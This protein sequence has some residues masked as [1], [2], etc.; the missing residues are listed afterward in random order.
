MKKLRVYADTSV[1]GGCFDEEF[2]EASK[3]F[4]E[5]VRAGRFEL[6]ISATTLR[7]LGDAPDRVQA[8][9]DEL[10]QELYKVVELTS[11]IESLRDKY[12][13]RGVVGTGSR[14][15]AEHI[16]AASA[17]GVDLIISWNFRHIVHFEKIRGYHAVNLVEGY[18]EIPIH[19]PREV[20]KRE[21]EGV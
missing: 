1:F 15:D 13:D 12:V 16:A 17:E 11:E 20:V 5:E 14:A 3:R 21:D 7:E 2:A 9:L 10:G 8:L 4:F 19:T 18:A 6:I